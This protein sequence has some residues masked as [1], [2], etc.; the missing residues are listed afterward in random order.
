MTGPSWSFRVF[1]GPKRL[2][3]FTVEGPYEDGGETPRL[4]TR[5]RWG[6]FGIKYRY[7]ILIEGDG[8]AS[9]VPYAQAFAKKLAKA[10]SGFAVDLQT[11]QIWPKPRKSAP[12]DDWFRSTDWGVEARAEFEEMLQSV[13]ELE[14]FRVCAYQGVRSC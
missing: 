4:S 2:Y 3:S 10:V 14:S 5:R 9:A 1:R 11:D 12:S 7:D 6:V 8:D 13:P